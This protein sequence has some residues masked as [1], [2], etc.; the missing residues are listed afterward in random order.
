MKSLQAWYKARDKNSAKIL[1]TIKFTSDINVNR[2]YQRITTWE[3]WLEEEHMEMCMKQFSRICQSPWNLYISLIKD[4]Q[5][6]NLWKKASSQSQARSFSAFKPFAWEYFATLT[7]LWRF[8][9]YI[10][11]HGTLWDRYVYFSQESSSE[12]RWKQNVAWKNY[13]RIDLL[14]SEVYYSSWSEIVKHSHQRQ[15]NSIYL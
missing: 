2:I 14:A 10:F 5:G 11:S 13:S 6:N 12:W 7:L 8:S 15:S 4:R 3:N 9:I 1:M